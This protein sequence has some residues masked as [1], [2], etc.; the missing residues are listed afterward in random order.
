[1]NHKLFPLSFSDCPVPIDVHRVEF[2]LAGF[3]DLS[4]L[5][6][7]LVLLDA[8]LDFLPADPGHLVRVADRQQGVLHH[9]EMFGL[10]GAGTGSGGVQQA[11]HTEQ[12]ERLEHD[13]IEAVLGTLRV[14]V[15]TEA[16]IV[17]QTRSG[18]V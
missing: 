6:D 4:L 9:Q 1:M 3:R 5:H 12:E 2:L 17:R 15:R 18:Q 8:G 14:P 7:C 16:F 11:G 10:Q 13:L